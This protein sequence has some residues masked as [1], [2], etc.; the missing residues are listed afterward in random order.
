ML[1]D[2]E[3]I[4]FIYPFC[5]SIYDLSCLAS[6]VQLQQ[7][8]SRGNHG[9]SKKPVI[10]AKPTSISISAI[11]FHAARGL[12]ARHEAWE[13]GPPKHGPARRPSSPGY[14]GMP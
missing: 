2:I 8:T 9:S 13:F 3:M 4:L 14:H 1:S 10:F 7:P 12:G 6:W 5:M 11:D